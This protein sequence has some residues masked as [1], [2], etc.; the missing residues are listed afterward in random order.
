MDSFLCLRY[1]FLVL[2]PQ[3][4]IFSDYIEKIK[5]ANKIS[6]ALGINSREKRRFFFVL[7][8]EKNTFIVQVLII[9]FSFLFSLFRMDIIFFFNSNPLSTEKNRIVENPKIHQNHIP[10]YPNIKNNGKH[11]LVLPRTPSASGESEIAVALNK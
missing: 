6:C 5:K 3:P 1:F 7:S 8:G 2:E 4:A 9:I 11:S 10:L